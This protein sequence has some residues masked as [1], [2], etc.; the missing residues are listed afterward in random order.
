[1]NFLKYSLP[2]KTFIGLLSKVNIS[3]QL[4]TFIWNV[5]KI[6]GEYLTEYNEK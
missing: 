6:C 5:F 1:M 4:A 2:Y 3:L